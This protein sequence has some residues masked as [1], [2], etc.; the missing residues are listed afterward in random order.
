MQYN[1][2]LSLAILAV[3]KRLQ[4]EMKIDGYRLEEN[5]IDI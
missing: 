4:P 2:L 5:N 1:F 3:T